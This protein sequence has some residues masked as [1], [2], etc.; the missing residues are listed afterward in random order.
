[1][2]SIPD[3]LAE[4]GPSAWLDFFEDS[5]SFFMASDGAVVFADPSAA[6]DFLADFAPRV[7]AMTLT[8]HDPRFEDL[9]GGVVAVTAGYD[10]TIR[11]TDGAESSFGG[12]M[13][14]VVRRTGGAWRLQHLH[15]SSP[16]APAGGP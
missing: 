7:S 3:A 12:R 5:P 1:V 6:R 13:S 11:M 10:E 16:V 14:G 15:W 4:R 2:A 9:G 8:W